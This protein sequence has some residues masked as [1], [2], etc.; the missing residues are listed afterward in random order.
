MLEKDRFSFCVTGHRPNQLFGYNIHLDKYDKIR[1]K[2]KEI[3]FSMSQAAYN[4]YGICTFRYISGMALGVDTIFFETALW[5]REHSNEFTVQV[6]AAVPFLGQESK[7]PQESR[8]EYH[9]LLKQADE[10][11]VVSDGSYAPWKMQKRNE[12]MVDHSDVVI[13]VYNGA[14]AGGTKNCVDYAVKKNK[15]IVIINPTDCSLQ[16][17][18]CELF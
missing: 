11:I 2:L 6:A 5:L 17:R 3:M 4:K 9:K 16:Y 10:T 18:S 15:A 12:F 8:N 14:K 13:A 1:E 7:W